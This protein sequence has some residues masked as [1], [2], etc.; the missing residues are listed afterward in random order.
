V[1]SPAETAAM[2]RALALAADP[3]APLGPNPRVGAVILA[4]DGRTVGEGFHHGAGTDHAEVVALQQAGAAARGGTAIVT[5]EPCNHQGRTGPCSQA[6][7]E[8]GIQRVVFAQS[9]IGH[10]AS[11]GRRR[12]SESAVDVESGVLEAEA[13]AVNPIFTKAHEL[14]RPYVTYKFAASLDGRIAAAD[15]T[16]QWITGAEAR[17]DAHRL[18]SEVDAVLVG[19]GTVVTDNP[20]LTVRD[21]G[22]VFVQPLRVVM[23]RRD[24]PPLATLSSDGQPTVH[25]RTHDPAVVLDDLARRGVTHVLVE[26]GPTVAG[27]FV[28]AGL[29]DR[30]IGYLAPLLLGGGRAALEDAGVASLADGLRLRVDDVTNLDGD[31]RVTGML[32]R[33]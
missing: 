8:A 24:L 14:G 6:L 10:L 18:R 21:V 13:A 31:V 1:A 15:G 33:K 27:A 12:L 28:R 5:L 16:S 23:G 26:G 3:Q 2:H 9:D 30:V 4:V 22:P 29:V 7:I 19:T 17:R 20:A 32:E 11:G 25:L